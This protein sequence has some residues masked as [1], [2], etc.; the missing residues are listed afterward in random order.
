MYTESSFQEA[1]RGPGVTLITHLYPTR[2]RMS[3][4]CLLSP[5]EPAWQ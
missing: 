3:K 1:K 2:S 5:L 4:S